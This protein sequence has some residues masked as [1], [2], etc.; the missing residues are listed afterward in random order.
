MSKFIEITFE[1]NKFL[2]NTSVIL[3]VGIDI[4][5]KSKSHIHFIKDYKVSNKTSIIVDQS[6]DE[7]KS[8]LMPVD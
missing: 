3:E 8:A 7:I 2:I 1:G 6:Y 4:A 5:S